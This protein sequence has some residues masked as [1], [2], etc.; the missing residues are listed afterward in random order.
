M[1]FATD[2]FFQR[3]PG[4]ERLEEP[5]LFQDPGRFLFY[6]FAIFISEADIGALTKTDP[7]GETVIPRDLRPV[8]ITRNPI[9]A[10]PN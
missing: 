1:C 6:P 5:L 8:C 3:C 4:I 7:S 2:E 9:L 10:E